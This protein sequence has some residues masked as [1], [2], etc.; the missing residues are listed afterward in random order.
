MI[1]KWIFSKLPKYLIHNNHVNNHISQ[2]LFQVKELKTSNIIYLIRVYLE[3]VI[4]NHNNFKQK[5]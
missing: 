1:L 2:Y 5:K 3:K 4:V